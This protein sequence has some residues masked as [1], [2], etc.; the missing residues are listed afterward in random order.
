MP[1][2]AC[3]LLEPGFL[4]AAADFPA[5]FGVGEDLACVRLLDEDGFVHQCL[6]D[7]NVEEAWVEL[8]VANLSSLSVVERCGCHGVYASVGFAACSGCSGAEDSA[9]AGIAGDPSLRISRSVPRCP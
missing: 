3:S 9:G 1:R 7:G 8:D 5:V 2:A 4:P 6:L